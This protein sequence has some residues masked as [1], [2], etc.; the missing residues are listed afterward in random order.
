MRDY[1]GIRDQTRIRTTFEP[2][3]CIE[4]RFGNI[5]NGTEA[6]LYASDRFET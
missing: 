2:D 5:D 4:R 6:R 1:G 3:L